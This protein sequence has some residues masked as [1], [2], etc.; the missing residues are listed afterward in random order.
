MSFHGV[1]RHETSKTGSRSRLVALSALAALLITPLFSGCGATD[2]ATDTNRNAADVV[3]AASGCSGSGALCEG[4]DLRGQDLRGVTFESSVLNGARFDGANLEGATF[5]GTSLQ[6]TSWQPPD[7]ACRLPFNGAH[8]QCATDYGWATFD[9]P[10]KTVVSATYGATGTG[11]FAGDG[12]SVTAA[13]FS[14]PTGVAISDDDKTIYVADSRNRRVRAV[15]V[16]SGTITT[17]AGSGRVCTFDIDRCGDGSPATTGDLSEPVGLA[18]DGVDKKLFIADQGASM[19]RA[20]DLTDNTISTVAG[21]GR[22]GYSGDDG[23]A[24][25]ARLAKPAGLT[26]ANGKLYISDLA[27]NSVRFVTLDDGMINRLAGSDSGKP[28]SQSSPCGDY[29]QAINAKLDSPND[30]AV[31]PS[32]YIAIA[33]TRD[34]A[35]RVVAPDG[36]IHS[37]ISGFKG[38]QES[39]AAEDP[40][41][42]FVDFD[43]DGNLYVGPLKDGK[44]GRIP[45]A[46]ITTKEQHNWSFPVPLVSGLGAGSLMSIDPHNRYIVATDPASQQVRLIVSD[47]G[48]NLK[49]VKFVNAAIGPRYTAGQSDIRT[50]LTGVIN[51]N[52]TFDNVNLDWA[53]INDSALPAA[54]NLIARKITA[55]NTTFGQLNQS[56]ISYARLNSIGGLDAVNTCIR[57]ATLTG[58]QSNWKLDRSTLAGASAEAN[59]AKV[60]F[61]N[62]TASNSA[63]SNTTGNAKWTYDKGNLTTVSFYNAAY[64]KPEITFNGTI[65]RNVPVRS[66]GNS[67]D[68]ERM[69]SGLSEADTTGGCKV[70]PYSATVNY[71]H[72]IVWGEYW[73]R[74]AYDHNPRLHIN[75]TFTA[76][77]QG[78][79]RTGEF[80]FDNM[81]RS[82]F[83]TVQSEDGNK[84]FEIPANTGKVDMTSQIQQMHDKGTPYIVRPGSRLHFDV[85]NDGWQFDPV[86]RGHHYGESSEFPQP[87]GSK[88]LVGQVTVTGHL[89]G[90]GLGKSHVNVKLETDGAQR[91]NKVSM[92]SDHKDKNL[93][94]LAIDSATK[95][96][97][98]EDFRRGSLSQMTS[99]QKVDVRVWSVKDSSKVLKGSMTMFDPNEPDG[100]DNLKAE[101]QGNGVIRVSWTKRNNGHNDPENY[102]IT[103]N[104]G[105]KTCTAAGNTTSCDFS[106]MTQQGTEVAYTFTAKANRGDYHR[107]LGST[108]LTLRDPDI[109]SPLTNFAAVYQGS[110][111]VKVTWQLPNDKSN[112]ASNYV[113]SASP[114]G[115]TCTATGTANGCDLTGMAP[116]KGSSIKYTITAVGNRGSFHPQVGSTELSIDAVTA[117]TLEKERDAE[118]ARLKAERDQKIKGLSS[119]D[120]DAVIK[121]VM[122]KTPSG[123]FKETAMYAEIDKATVA[124]YIAQGSTE[125]EARTE[126]DQWYALIDR[127]GYPGWQTKTVSEVLTMFY[128]NPDGDFYG[129]PSCK[130]G[131]MMVALTYP[132]AFIGTPD[133]APLA[134]TQFGILANQLVDAVIADDEIA[135]QRNQINNDYQAKI[136]AVTSEYAKRIAD[137]KD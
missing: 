46:A 25:E 23:P 57:N 127:C 20:V 6:G 16:A 103:A 41:P 56:D 86:V 50:S 54:T 51:Q 29:G 134:A 82:T 38:D 44:L 79:L 39:E 35:I 77:D 76:D 68:Q 131:D 1:G 34:R 42:S 12:G 111:V 107:D 115:S 69:P 137:L 92:S 70:A 133:E 27:N 4:K 36:S 58:T 130:F 102:V 66:G 94:M 85:R 98:P 62:L 105:G 11:Q 14:G 125:S 119:V 72:E 5:I 93:E 8:A 55:T 108:Q 84:L 52:T 75:A 28:C 64:T 126:I 24:E 96:S 110:G 31:S 3:G 106:K 99:G 17:I 71:A 63:I 10:L 109:P 49:N 122:S 120:A 121:E 19:I 116:P 89:D 7:G 33:D 30:V 114:G 2:N 60:K 80:T 61:D 104:P 18:Y 95:M 83:I 78:E 67:P 97:A 81:P 113:V 90:A 129:D 128:L 15:D 74:G 59:G 124:E 21:N 123:P 43:R 117:A 48:P 13:K 100:V 132:L 32:G 22:L 53:K 112:P 9:A 40:R 47:V 73:G 26:Y 136:D 45:A 65:L 87:Q 135:A 88:A 101:N 91:L 118:I 37:V